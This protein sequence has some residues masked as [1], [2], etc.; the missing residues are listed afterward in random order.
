M[1]VQDHFR[2]VT[3]LPISTYFSSYKLKWLIDNVPKVSKAI[4]SE[5]AYLGKSYTSTN[6]TS[7]AYLPLLITQ[8][9]CT[10]VTCHYL[11]R[12]HHAFEQ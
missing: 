8:S 6:M 10:G 11:S 12:I 4:S 5:Q 3:G 2:P 1:N 7:H 9:T